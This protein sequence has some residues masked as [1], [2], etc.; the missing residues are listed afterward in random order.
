[1]VAK[2]PLRKFI[3]DGLQVETLPESAVE[4]DDLLQSKELSLATWFPRPEIFDIDTTNYPEKFPEA[5][6]EQMEKYGVVGWYDWG[7]KF[8]G[9]KWDC[10][11]D[12]FQYVENNDNSVISFYFDSPWS[13]ATEWFINIQE[14]YPDLDFEVQYIEP[15]M[16]FSGEGS[17]L[18]DGDDVTFDVIDFE[19]WTESPLFESQGYDEYLE[20]EED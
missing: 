2:I 18:R 19:D 9:C 15:G 16:C 3:K 7:L 14:K 11:F 8:Y 12:A 1:V 17:T 5:V 6:K 20:E 10:I 13:P 4:I